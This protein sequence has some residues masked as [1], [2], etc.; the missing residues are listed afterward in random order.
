MFFVTEPAFEHTQDGQHRWSTS[1]EPSQ[2]FSTFTVPS[3]AAQV[4]EE[5][6][7]EEVLCQSGRVA[8]PAP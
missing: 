1:A 4:P 8:D 3:G 5:P 2:T 7:P 6:E